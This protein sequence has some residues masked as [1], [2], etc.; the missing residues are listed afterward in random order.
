MDW[1][2]IIPTILGGG[3]IIYLV[4]EHLLNRRK[5]AAENK[6]KD[7]ENAHSVT[8]LYKEVDEIVER[9]TQPILDNQRKLLDEMNDI[10]THWCCY[11]EKCSDRILY[12]PEDD[13]DSC[14][15]GEA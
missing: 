8:D 15:G 9:K 12:K 14:I 7:I 4:V 13:T 1:A 2:T 3:S 5:N 10:K 11:R 6:G